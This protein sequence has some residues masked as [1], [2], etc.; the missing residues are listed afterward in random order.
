MELK[1]FIKATITSIGESIGELNKEFNGKIIA[2]PDNMYIHHE[3]SGKEILTT[4]RDIDGEVET[5]R[6]LDIEFNLVISEVKKDEKGGGL[7]IEVFKAGINNKKEMENHNTVKF[8]I[9]VAFF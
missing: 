4:N 1:E 8:S 7:S 5:R 9:P 2:N 6:I 3:S